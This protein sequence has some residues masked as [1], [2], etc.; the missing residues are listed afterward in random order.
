MKS[1]DIKDAYKAVKADAEL[2]EKLLLMAEEVNYGDD[3]PTEDLGEILITE[4]KGGKARRLLNTV[5]ALAAAVA[6]IFTVRLAVPENMGHS[7]P[8]VDETVTVIEPE[9]L[10]PDTAEVKIKV[11]DQNGIFVKNRRVDYIPIIPPEAPESGYA[12]F[13]IRVDEEHLDRMGNIPMTFDE[14]VTIRIHYGTYFF[15]VSE[16]L[17]NDTFGYETW[18]YRGEEHTDFRLTGMSDLGGQQQIITVDENTSE[19]VFTDYGGVRTDGMGEGEIII[20][21]AEGNPIPDCTVILKPKDGVY[22][23]G[24]TDT[25]GG[26]VLHRTDENGSVI[27]KTPIE[28]EY[29]VIAYRERPHPADEPIT[30]PVIIDGDDSYTYVE[31]DSVFRTYK[32][33]TEAGKTN[34]TNQILQTLKTSAN[35]RK[36]VIGMK[37]KG[38]T[39]AA[40]VTSVIAAMF[41][42]PVPSSYA[43]NEADAAVT[44]ATVTEAV[45][46]ETAVTETT[47]AEITETETEKEEVTEKEEKAKITDMGKFKLDKSGFAEA[48]DGN[49]IFYYR[50]ASAESSVIFSADA[51]GNVLNSYSFPDYDRFNNRTP[52]IKALDDCV[53]LTYPGTD[54]DYVVKLDKELNEISKCEIEK[55]RDFDCDGEKIV[56]ATKNAIKLCGLDG[57]NMQTV[58]TASNGVDEFRSVAMNGK[59]IGFGGTGGEYPDTKYYSG[60][61]DRVTGEATVKQQDRKIYNVTAF[62][63][64]L[65]WRTEA[66]YFD[67]SDPGAMFSKQYADGE[68]YI[69][70]G[71]KIYTYRTES[72]Y[73]RLAVDGKG[74]IITCRVLNDENRM[75]VKVCRDGILQAESF[76]LDGTDDSFYSIAANG[77]VIAVCTAQYPEKTDWET[78][79]YTRFIS[80]DE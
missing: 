17:A 7:M 29:T 46:T 63:D 16:G 36:E 56:I 75:T 15:F 41:T 22:K 57:G 37:K 19:I 50:S 14:S 65:V 31:N 49:G 23:E 2:K 68:Y 48:A 72:P 42:S 20:H 30:D 32:I 76:E 45:V 44:E 6:V 25:Y 67:H 12:N 58:W 77:G 59:Y 61:I 70:D 1:E 35:N 40:A 10:P 27:W 5:C 69:Y 60:V 74:N 38:I 53:V 21:D 26:Y 66:S 55:C 28:G 24:Y 18:S 51:K 8:T 9:P 39:F 52:R 64:F 80:Y 79:M 78:V 34:Q 11:V 3:T 43:L 33:Y 54:H 13:D 71:S 47:V 62:G 73:E 4:K